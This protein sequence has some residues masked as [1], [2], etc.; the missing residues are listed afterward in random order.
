M[1]RSLGLWSTETSPLLQKRKYLWETVVQ[2]IALIFTIGGTPLPKHF[3][4]CHQ[5]SNRTI[6]CCRPGDKPLPEPMMVS[7]LMHICVI[8]PQWVNV[9]S[10]LPHHYYKPQ[11]L[12]DVSPALFCSF[13]AVS[14]PLS[15]SVSQN[16]VKSLILLEIHLW[17]LSNMD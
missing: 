16:I 2:I 1:K 10:N 17:S 3:Y 12:E 13:N 14:M 5:F 15:S 8:W 7:S 4:R 9:S 11:V 6:A